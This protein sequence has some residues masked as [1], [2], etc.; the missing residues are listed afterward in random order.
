MKKKLMSEGVYPSNSILLRFMKTTRFLFLLGI[1]NVCAFNAYSQN[2]RVTMNHT[3]TPLRI[4]LNDIESQ[5]S[6]LFVIIN[7]QVDTQKAYSI[8]VESKP[9][10]AVLDKLF[11]GENINY[12]MQGN[13]IVLSRESQQN[14]PKGK[15]TLTG[16]IKDY[17][18]EPLVGASIHVKGTQQGTVT[19][20]NGYFHIEGDYDENQAYL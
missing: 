19:D 17:S 16:Y 15:R 12:K 18:G 4:I 20:L 7:S 6:Y 11:E 1:L 2:A 8:N 10:S 5:T 14:K 9:V 13:H 3:N